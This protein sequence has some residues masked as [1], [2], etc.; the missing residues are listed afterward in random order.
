MNTLS[1]ER[2]FQ[3]RHVS[4]GDAGVGAG[5]AQIPF[6]EC[7]KFMGVIVPFQK[8]NCGVGGGL[9][10]LLNALGPAVAASCTL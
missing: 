3:R 2:S 10:H 4:R 5:E 7:F 9:L 8:P 6:L 1:G